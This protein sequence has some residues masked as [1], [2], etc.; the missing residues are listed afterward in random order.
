MR[1]T[2][3][4]AP[5]D[6]RLQH[7]VGTPLVARL[8]LTLPGR[9]RHDGRDLAVERAARG[10]TA[11]IRWRG[12]P[13]GRAADHGAPPRAS[14]RRACAPSSCVDGALVGSSR[15]AATTSPVVRWSVRLAQGTI[16]PAAIDSRSLRV[17]SACALRHRRFAPSTT[18]RRANNIAAPRE[19][20]NSRSA[21]RWPRLTA[22]VRAW[23]FAPTSPRRRPTAGPTGSRSSVVRSLAGTWPASTCA[24]ATQ[25]P[26][27]Q[28]PPTTTSHHVGRIESSA[29]P[30]LQG[31]AEVGGVAFDFAKLLIPA[32]PRRRRRRA[33]AEQAHA[34]HRRDQ[35]VRR[36]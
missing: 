5:T 10:R 36:R 20:S 3:T 32:P 27:A 21:T 18:G 19:A 26:S 16:Q 28:P 13:P 11:P 23:R 30:A 33:P 14:A 25:R 24:G 8:R 4:A 2:L 12:P 22:Q 17:R 1:R 7:F 29:Y 31:A 34:R 35:R 15:A 9:A 6:L